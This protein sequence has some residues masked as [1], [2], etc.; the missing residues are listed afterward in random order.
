MTFFKGKFSIVAG[1]LFTR[2]DVLVWKQYIKF[3]RSGVRMLQ[4][5]PMNTSDVRYLQFHIRFDDATS[6]LL[7]TSLL[8]L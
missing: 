4:T 3:A 8:P 2:T 7:C 1:S 6:E 5:L